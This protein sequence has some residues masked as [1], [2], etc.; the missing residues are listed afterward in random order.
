MANCVVE[1]VGAE[2]VGQYRDQQSPPVEADGAQQVPHPE[3]GYGQQGAEPQALSQPIR[4][5]HGL[6]NPEERAHRPQVADGLVGDGAERPLRFPQAGRVAQ[7]ASRIQ[8]EVDLGVDS[9]PSG[10]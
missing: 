6:E 3:A 9:N 10:A 5:T 8:I 4:Q 7:Q 1:Q 2:F